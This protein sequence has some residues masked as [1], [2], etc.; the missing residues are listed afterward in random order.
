MLAGTAANV[1]L[2]VL[3]NLISDIVGGIRVTVI[4][5]E[6]VRRPAPEPEPAHDGFGDVTSPGNG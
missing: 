3:F 5:E 4:E 6:V 1:L 2:A